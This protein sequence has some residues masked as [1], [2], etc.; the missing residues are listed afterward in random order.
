VRVDAGYPTLAAPRNRT[1]DGLRAYAMVGVVLGHWLV[2]GLAADLDG[3]LHQQSPLRSLP[4][5]TPLSWVLQTLGL[6]FFVSGY[7]AAS[8]RASRSA[9]ASSRVSRSAAAS[10]RISRSAAASSQVSRSAA[11][12]SPVSRS[13][14]ASSQVSRSAAASSRVF[15]YAAA[16][17]RVGA[18]GGR[19]ASRWPVARMRRLAQ[20]VAGLLVVWLLADA[21]LYATH[22][23]APTRHVIGRLMLSPL[24]FVLVL[25]VLIVVTPAVCA[26]ER[27]VGPVLVLAPLALTVGID[28]ARYAVWPEIPDRLTYLN[29][30]TA[31]LVPYVLGVAVAHGHLRHRATGAVLLVVGTIGGTQLIVAAGYPASMVGVPGAGRSNLD[32]PSL[33]T[34]ALSLVQIGLALLAWSRLSRLLERPAWSTAS[35]VLNRSAMTVFLWHQAALLIVVGIGHT[36]LDD[37]A[38]LVGPPADASWVWGRL[39]WL[40]AFVAVLAVLWLLFRRIEHPARPSTMRGT[41]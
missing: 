19:A 31:W 37:P 35:A 30:V 15:G 1:V 9:A 3:G 6:F 22:A 21:V 38:G 34:V 39:S 25:A 14:A 41:P 12:S 5:F 29:G 16:P 2:T 7:A 18:T 13:A 24:W 40:P 8:S 27:R 26:A 4:V 28:L 23:A 33:L 32:P 11:A 10:N 36:V 20:P 17:S